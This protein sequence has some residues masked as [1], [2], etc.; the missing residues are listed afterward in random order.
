MPGLRLK[1]EQVQRLC[2]I[3][4]SDEF[5]DDLVQYLFPCADGTVHHHL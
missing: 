1:P 2:G 5:D 3:E 4:L